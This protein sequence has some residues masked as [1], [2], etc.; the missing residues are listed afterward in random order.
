[1]A[2]EGVYTQTLLIKLKANFLVRYLLLPILAAKIKD[3][4]KGRK[5]ERERKRKSEIEKE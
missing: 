4:D 1:M 2:D 3:R 5:K